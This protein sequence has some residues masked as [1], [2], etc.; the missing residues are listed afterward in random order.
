MR[1]DWVEVELESICT[2]ITKGGT[3]TTYGFSFKKEGINFIK[4]ESISNGVINPNYITDFISEEAHA[5]QI[6]SQLSTG[7]LLFSIA[8]TIGRT[9]IVNE[10]ILPANTNQALSIIRVY[11]K[12]TSAKF[13]KFQLDSFVSQITK[14]KARGGAMNNISL[15]D[16]KKLKTIIPP[17]PEQRAIVAKIEQLFSELDNGI[18]NLKAAQ[19]K[20]GVYRQAVLKQAF[21]G[22]LTREWGGKSLGIAHTPEIEQLVF[23]DKIPDGWIWTNLGS[24][25]NVSGGLTKNSK[26]QDLSSQYPFL[27]VANVYS[28]KL[29]L[30]EIHYIGVKESELNRVL[31]KE[32]DLLIV[33]GNGSIDQI[34]R[35]AIWRNEIKNCVHQNHLIKARPLDYIGPK[36]VLYFLTSKKGRD[37]II[38]EASSTSGLH[39]L[40]LSKVSNL[41]IPLCP[42]E[43][44]NQI[45]QEIEARLSVCDKLAEII[46]TSLQQAEALRQSILKKAFE[47]RLLTST[48]LQAC[49]KEPDWTPAQQLLEQIK[50]NAN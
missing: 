13:I 15:G 19:S 30:D 6:K 12:I 37:L 4:V 9:C 21:E 41:K 26:R 47:G 36:Y 35:V 43:E 50:K 5:Y 38:Q 3:P 8:G 39:T 2:R 14:N 22:E 18:A 27:R 33:E 48:E 11:E 16:L 34:G 46:Q 10:A 25:C 1:A 29:I 49:R 44:Q 17:I 42:V 45:V 20:L 31:L 23:E 28:N 24:V 7:D 40:S 32:N